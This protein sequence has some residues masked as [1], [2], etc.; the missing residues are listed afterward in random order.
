MNRLYTSALAALLAVGMT[1]LA[2]CSDED[3]GGGNGGEVSKG[4]GE[5][6]IAVKASSGTE[7]VMQTE[8]LESG[9]LNI[10]QNVM[11]LPQQE[12]T[13]IFRDNLAVGLVYQQQNPG[14][15]Y[16]LRLL[17]DLSLEKMG[18]FSITTRYSNYGF[19]EDYLV[20]SVAGQV[21]ADGSRNDGATFAFW[22]LD[23]DQ[24][25]LERTKTLWT[26]D[27]TG[28]GEQVTFSS[29]VD[30]G[31]GEFLS[32]MVQS[33]F[34]QTGTG[35]GSSVG[36]VAYPDSVWVAALDRDLNI[37]RIYRDDRISYSAGQYRSQVFPQVGRADDGTVYVFSSAF[38]ANTTRPCGALRIRPGAEEF[39][40]AYYYN[41]AD[42][43]GGYTFRRVWHAT[44]SKFLLEI[45][46][47][48]G[49]PG[50]TDPGHQFAVV[51]MEAKSFAWVTGLPAKN[52]ITSGTETG[53][54]PMCL[55]GKIYLPITEFKQDAAVYVIADLDNP[56]AVKG[57][58]LKGVSEIRSLGHLK[59]EQ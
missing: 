6:F 41:L 43:T 25:T 23:G 22:N 7:Y 48:T 35:T 5:Y 30:M 32:S 56:V 11:E 31:N 13:W 33:S 36:T 26:E 59:A 55:N 44:G 57:A 50:M 49:K 18:E 19:F 8:S 27:I 4:T 29:I 47:S 52:L 14:I 46:N 3:G 17:P 38:D 51:D 9:E 21:S 39:D 12:Y 34:K 15:G 10:S 54:V 40:P 58:V 28:N 53:G 45:Y 2:S 42:E 24:V 1:S 16:A 20:T 37:K